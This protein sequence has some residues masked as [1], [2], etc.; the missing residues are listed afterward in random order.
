MMA[1]APVGAVPMVA[2]VPVVAITTV[3]LLNARVLTRCDFETTR[4]AA[5]RRGLG[6]HHQEAQRQGSHRGDE[7]GFAFHS[8]PLLCHF[9]ASALV[10]NAVLTFAG[11]IQGGNGSDAGIPLGSQRLDLAR[12]NNREPQLAGRARRD[13][14]ANCH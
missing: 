1:M 5:H 3:H 14:P 9:A 11:V 13:H 6:G 12:A 4:H 8:L 2:A 10:R 7:P